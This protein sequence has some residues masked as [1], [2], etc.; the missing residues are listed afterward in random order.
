MKRVEAL[1]FKEFNKV[2]AD[3]W[4][5]QELGTGVVPFKEVYGYATSFNRDWWISAEQDTTKLDPAEAARVNFEY[6]DNLRKKG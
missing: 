4:E 1:H 6:I 3:T 2:S 5:I